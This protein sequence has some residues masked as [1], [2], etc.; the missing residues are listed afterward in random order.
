M[1]FACGWREKQER[2]IVFFAQKSAR[3]FLVPIKV[4]LLSEWILSFEICQTYD[5]WSSDGL[6]ISSNEETFRKTGVSWGERFEFTFQTRPTRLLITNLG[7]D[8]MCFASISGDG[9]Q[10][11]Q[12]FW[13]NDDCSTTFSYPCHE[14]S[15]S[16]TVDTPNRN[17]HRSPQPYL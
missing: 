12:Y 15:V 6:V 4:V 2:K 11:L 8:G 13:I 7:S 1:L 9:I 5:S 10:T 14:T 16:I 3:F 17:F